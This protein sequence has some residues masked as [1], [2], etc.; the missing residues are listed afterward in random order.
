ML[1][2]SQQPQGPN[3]RPRL[4]QNN[5]PNNATGRVIRPVLHSFSE[6]DQKFGTHCRGLLSLVVVTRTV[7][8]CKEPVERRRGTFNAF[9]AIA[10][11]PLVVRTLFLL[12]FSLTLGVGILI[13]CDL[14]LRMIF[15]GLVTNRNAA[16]DWFCMDRSNGFWKR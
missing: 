12:L 8:A 14:K 9:L 10:L 6:L 5:C 4:N 2:L 11:R 13:L 1:R 7:S 3:L 15:R 16:P